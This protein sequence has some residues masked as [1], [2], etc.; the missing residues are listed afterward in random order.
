VKIGDQTLSVTC[1]KYIGKSIKVTVA[2]IT[3]VKQDFALVALIVTSVSGM[4]TDRS[5]GAPIKGAVVRIYTNGTNKFDTTGADG[6]YQF[7]EVGTGTVIMIISATGFAVLRDTLTIS[8]TAP[9]THNIALGGRTAVSVQHLSNNSTI[10]Q[11]LFSGNTFAITNLSG[12]GK[13]ALFSLSGKC[14]YKAV[15]N[16]NRTSVTIP[17]NILSSG[18]SLVAQ[19]TVEGKTWTQQILSA[20]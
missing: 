8:G 19:M 4:V 13:I 5:K 11:I 9:V 17:S 14:V 1:S 12:A 18:L 10:P 7:A 15:F 3:P 2:G 6:K 16:K 20:K